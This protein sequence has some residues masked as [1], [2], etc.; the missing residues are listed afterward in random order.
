MSVLAVAAVLGGMAV[1]VVGAEALV[2]GASR[3]AAAAG[4]SALVIGLTVVAYGTSAPELAVSVRDAVTGNGEVAVGNAVGSNI[5]NVLAILGLSA[6]F[7][8]LIVHSRLVRVD[9]PLLL[10]VTAGVW[11][12][13]SDGMIATVEGGVLVA[14]ILVYSVFS[15]L[16]GR[17]EPP[18]V[19]QEYEEAFGTDPSAARRRWPAAA[20]LVGIGLLGLVVGAQLLVSGA[21]SIA[22]HL[23][24]SQLIIGLTI[25]AVGT[26]LPELATSVIATR[27]GERD[28][29][30]GNIIGSN[31]FNLLAVLG[32]SALAG[33][34][35]DVPPDAIATDLPVTLLVTLIALPALALGLSI[36][37][38]EGVLL[39]AAY[40]GYVGYLLL[41]AIDSPVAAAGRLWLLA[42]L[43]LMAVAIALLGLAIER[44]HRA[45]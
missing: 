4:V 19:T 27:R 32:A 14:G 20:G 21:T 3:L 38:W 8:G 26:S 12:L 29:A 28:I 25:V 7:G 36:A 24:V 41:H 1:L 13:A 9:V 44:G 45:G 23:G 34:G 6:V 16:L 31:L 18:G 22:E 40:L 33:G 5:F 37:R 39:L 10:V 17:R 35:I 42:G 2:R 15:Y 43:A 30:V 11:W